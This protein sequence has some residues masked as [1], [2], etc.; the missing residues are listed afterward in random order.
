MSAVYKDVTYNVSKSNG[1]PLSLVSNYEIHL[2]KL[3]C[4]VYTAKEQGLS[5]CGKFIAT[6]RARNYIRSLALV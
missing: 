1:N 6:G 5:K 3:K 4:Y 2:Y